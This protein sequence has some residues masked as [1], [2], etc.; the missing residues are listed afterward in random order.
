M[1]KRLLQSLGIDSSTF[2]TNISREDEMLIYN[3]EQLEKRKDAILSYYYSGSQML[4]VV[5]QLIVWRFGS[6]KNITSFLDFACGYGRFTRHLVQLIDPEK[7][8]VSDIYADAVDFQERE[9]GVT[10][11]VSAEDPADYQD[12]NKYDFIFVASLFS[13]LSRD[14]FHAWLEKLLTLLAPGGVLAF[15]VHDI[16]FKPE[17]LETDSDGMSFY[18]KSESR[19]LD[20][21]IYGTTYV[22]EGFVRRAIDETAGG[23]CSV[24]RLA[25]GL[26]GFQDIYVVTTGQVTDRSIPKIRYGPIG[27]LDSCEWQGNNEIFLSGW[28]A[29]PGYRSEQLRVEVRVNGKV[30]RQCKPNLER[31]DVA[32]HLEDDMFLHSGWNCRIAGG[33]FS[34]DDLIEVMAINS[35]EQKLI[36]MFQKV[37]DIDS[38]ISQSIQECKEAHR[39]T[40]YYEDA[41]PH[42]ELQWNNIIWPKIKDFD[43]SKVLELAPG[44]GRNTAFLIKHAGEIALVDVNQHC[45]DACR[46]RFAGEENCNLHYIVNDGKSLLGIPDSSITMIYSWDSMVHF[47]KE[48]VKLYTKEFARVLAPGGKGFVHH[49]NY[50]HISQSSDWLSH[51][52]NRSNMTDE[53]F[54]QYVR[55]NGMEI[56][57]QELLDWDLKDLDCIS[58]FRKP[59]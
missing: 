49:S 35:E 21:E 16:Y 56:V 51:P 2:N 52:H 7:I 9:F 15:S 32:A 40:T 6:M 20:P 13:H 59:E 36:M 5:R 33:S 28:T 24:Y 42:M 17:S 23:E 38:P 43:F 14:A 8:R 57:S 19:S 22:T 41:E 26:C 25:K 48:V 34:S 45:I 50:G 39:E 12:E 55:D 46:E 11:Y 1:F 31:Q 29:E 58:V 4:D 18:P 27:N 37:E 53:L 44:F 30:V 47:D 54:A 3:L 10:G